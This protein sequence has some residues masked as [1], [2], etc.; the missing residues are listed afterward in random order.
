MTESP[1]AQQPPTKNAEAAFEAHRQMVIALFLATFTLGV[2]LAVGLW[3][4]VA[5]M[6]LVVAA[7]GALGGFI[8]ALRRLYAFKPVF[9]ANFFR[10][11][12]KVDFYLV[13][14]SMIPAAVGAV[15]AVVL[16]VLF[17]S[18]LLKGDLFPAFGWGGEFKFDKFHNFVQNWQP[19][20]AQDYA[21]A[22][23]W[24]FI[25]GFSERFVPDLLNQFAR[26]QSP[27]DVSSP[28]GPPM[29]LDGDQQSK[30][31]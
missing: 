6:L 3:K 12:A 20:C 10:P 18:G 26:Q 17:A 1:K 2:L 29:T 9:P 8:S 19:T 25:A 28:G 24:S 21:K 22:L 15:G 5:Q 4:S 7:A 27:P 23:V 11:R 30:P 16:Y 13:V 31:S 14:Y